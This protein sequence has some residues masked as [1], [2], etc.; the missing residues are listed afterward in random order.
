[1]LRFF[2][3]L[4]SIAVTSIS[5]A[6]SPSILYLTWTRDPSTTMTIQWHTGKN[7]KE[8]EV[9]FRQLGSTQWQSKEGEYRPLH[10]TDYLAHTVELDLLNPDVDYEFVI[11]G[12]PGVYKFRTMPQ[13]MQRPVRFAVGGDAYYYYSNFRKMNAQ[14]AAQDP[15]FIIVGGDIAYS[16]GKRA[17]FNTKNWEFNRWRTFLKEWK[18][19]MVTSDGRLIPILP[20]VG[21]HDVKGHLNPINH[22]LFFYEIFA[23]PQTGVSYRHLDF[24][25]YLSLLL[26]D[27]GHT[28]PVD[29]QQADWLKSTLSSRENFPYKFA[30]YHIGAYPSVYPYQGAR[31]RQIRENWSPAFE[32]YHLTGAFE[33]HNHAYKR[34]HPIKQ[35]QIDPDGVVY[36][37]DGSWGTSPRKVKNAKMWYLLK[38]MQE[39]A[40]FVVTLGQH[41]GAIEALSIDGKVI[42]AAVAHPGSN[43]VSF[44][45]SRLIR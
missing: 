19:Q 35:E 31:A 5:Y 43:L 41:L 45:E 40:V 29:G 24:G 26:L 37:G 42:D 20:V 7:E 32:Q 23:F 8:T 27:S 17:V 11:Q 21:N 13:H 36:Y 9:L 6:A 3:I 15:D 30:A 10:A 22:D 14:I 28:Y 38:G 25:N 18:R 44:N 16:N 34:T 33:H 2:L 12:K 1:M 4:F 39:S